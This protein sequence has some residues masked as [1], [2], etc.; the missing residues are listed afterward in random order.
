[1]ELFQRL[2]Q[3]RQKPAFLWGRLESAV[4]NENIYSFFRHAKGWSYSKYLVTVNVGSEANNHSYV[5]SNSQFK[6]PQKGTVV[7]TTK[8]HPTRKDNVRPGDKVSLENFT[9]YPGEGFVIVLKLTDNI[10]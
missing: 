4:Y 8:L 6:C 2:H 3:L 1:M 10:V 9:L 5:G 7:A